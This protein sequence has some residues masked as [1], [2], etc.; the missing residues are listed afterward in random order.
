MTL[1]LAALAFLSPSLAA[2]GHHGAAATAS[3]AFHEVLLRCPARVWPGIDWSELQIL[4][5]DSKATDAWLV[6]RAYR[7]PARVSKDQTIEDMF[8]PGF[9]SGFLE[10]RG[11]HTLAVSTDRG[12]DEASV[13]TAVTGLFREAVQAEWDNP[14]FDDRGHLFP[15][16]PEPRYFRRMVQENL[17]RALELL[18]AGRD[19]RPALE[20]AAWWQARWKKY[21]PEELAFRTEASDGTALYAEQTAR[22][23]SN[24]GCAAP[25]PEFH[26]GL[27]RVA[28]SE[29]AL[30]TGAFHAREGA[31]IGALSSFLLNEL[32]PGWQK[33]MNGRLMPSD[34][35]FRGLAYRAQPERHALLR[36]YRD[37][38]GRQQALARA[39][40]EPELYRARDKSFVRVSVPGSWQKGELDVGESYVH[41]ANKSFAYF[42]LGRRSQ[43]Q[44]DYGKAELPARA[45]L[46][47]GP[48]PCGGNG[49][50]FLVPASAI[51][52]EDGTGNSRIFHASWNGISFRLRG[53]SRE[54]A[55]YPW[56]CPWL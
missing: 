49:L 19:P 4:F 1:L 12:P 24:L 28:R 26:G 34:L 8:E 14:V 23:L 45:V 29:L 32:S 56:V 33:Q 36:E 35:L 43:F 54:L 9:T 16:L 25:A 37:T 20:T 52:K 51:R 41:R 5:S 42:F 53:T 10:F 46:H 47:Q 13:R 39:H 48:N 21:F 55:G 17:L 31:L 30:E 44:G 18:A 38:V 50:S 2:A 11:R 22:L 27:R 15:L 3:R 40:L 7:E 6:G